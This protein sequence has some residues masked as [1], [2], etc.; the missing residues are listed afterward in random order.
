MGIFPNPSSSG[1]TLAL[2]L[3]TAAAVR[4]VVYDALGR[5]VI[6]LSERPVSGSAQLRLGTDRLASGVYVV[7]VWADDEVV[8]RRM[9]VVR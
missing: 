4:A 8:T 2:R 1:A 6:R 3:P 5:E 9:T 7:R